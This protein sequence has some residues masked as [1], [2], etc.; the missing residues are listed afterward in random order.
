[1]SNNNNT[2][3]IFYTKKYD[4]DVWCDFLCYFVSIFWWCT[5]FND[6]APHRPEL[7][8]SLIGLCCCWCLRVVELCITLH[9]QLCTSACVW[10]YVYYKIF[11]R[12]S[13]NSHLSNTLFKIIVKLQCIDCN[14]CEQC[15]I[16]SDLPPSSSSFLRKM[17]PWSTS[18]SENL[19][20]DS[21]KKPQKSIPTWNKKRQN[22]RCC[23]CCTLLYKGT[24]KHTA[25]ENVKVSKMHVCIFV[26]PFF[27]TRKKTWEVA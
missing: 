20:Q 5:Y 6:I 7:W 22:Y 13:K 2:S 14:P 12:R 11:S 1:M 21:R 24:K 23:A 27:I 4:D 16:R 19:L 3:T 15:K 8:S 10:V 18:S 17:T 25:T 26:F 9:C